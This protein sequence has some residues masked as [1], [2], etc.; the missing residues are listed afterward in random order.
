M[1][2]IKTIVTL[3][4][5]SNKIEDLKLMK[6]KLVD[7]VRIN[8]CHS[9]LDDLE[10]FI[11]LAKESDIEF[12]IDT[13]GSQI[14]TGEVIDNEVFFREGD[15]ILI[16][17]D[18]RIGNKSELS[19]KPVE[20]L[21]Q[22]EIGDLLYVDFDTLVIQIVEI[23]T[24]MEEPHLKGLILSSGKLGSNKGIFIDSSPPEK[25]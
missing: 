23:H 18:G 8:M 14:R 25:L 16:F 1:N 6:N 11:Q 3:G 7:F 17:S 22:I 10:N 4:P 2:N 15:F 21:E 19:I 12:I 5:A 24:Y 13:E 20:V 9:N